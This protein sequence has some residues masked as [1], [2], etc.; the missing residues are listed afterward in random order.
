MSVRMSETL[1]PLGTSSK[2]KREYVGIFLFGTECLMCRKYVNGGGGEVESRMKH[3]WDPSQPFWNTS[4]PNPNWTCNVKLP[5]LARVSGQNW[6]NDK[7]RFGFALK[8]LHNLIMMSILHICFWRSDGKY[9]SISEKIFGH[10]QV[11]HPKVGNWAK[12][13]NF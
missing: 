4:Q 13:S 6:Q 8:C 7:L 3:G 5:I 11:A 12:L 2:K 10:L 9:F 1:H